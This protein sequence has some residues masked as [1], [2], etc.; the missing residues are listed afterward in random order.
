MVAHDN[1]N[2]T[3]TDTSTKHLTDS[4]IPDITA[5]IDGSDVRVR[6]TNG[7]GYTF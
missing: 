4:T 5:D 3:F 6:V 1:G 2:I 7:N